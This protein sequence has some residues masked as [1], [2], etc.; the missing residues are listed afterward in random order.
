MFLLQPS[1]NPE[2]VTCINNIN[3]TTI[4]MML[5][6]KRFGAFFKVFLNS[7]SSGEREDVLLSSY[8]DGLE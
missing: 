2:Y 8:C 1:T 6:K 3:I 5:L 4:A 7:K